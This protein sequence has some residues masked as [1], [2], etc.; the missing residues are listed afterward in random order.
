[1]TTSSRAIALACVVGLSSIAFASPLYAQQPSE[2]S[3]ADLE[4]ARE[5]YKEGKELRSKGDLKG[6]LEKF[7]AAHAYGGT[8]VT[9]LEL[10]KTHMQLGDLV[11]AREIFL[12]VGR[13]RVQS[14]E[15]EKSNAARTEAA[16]LAEQLKG[17]IATVVVKV[18]GTKETA[19]VTVDGA[20]APVVSGTA[21]RRI[22][23][24]QHVIVARAGS[25]EKKENVTLGEGETKEVP[26][27]L[28]SSTSSNVHVGDGKDQPQPGGDGK[29][30]IHIVTWV[31]LGV[32]VVG[33]GVGTVTGILA[34]GKSGN[35]KDAC[36]GLSC[37]ESARPD[38]EDGRTVATISTIGFI[39]AG[40][41]VALAAVGYFVLSKPS[42]SNQASNRAVVS[43]SPMGLRGTF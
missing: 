39:A 32:A 1:M 25:A 38:V 12:S 4:S 13:M 11:E 31:G 24:G 6:A 26:I 42:S 17:K 40:A 28:D 23:P 30:S 29:R 41:G 2:P 9:G 18:T 20:N 33:A 15:T 16:D 37:P 36:V 5:L 34:L 21:T 22:N 35:V 3:A 43:F 14:D 19:Q 10:G 7:K 27:A 8:P